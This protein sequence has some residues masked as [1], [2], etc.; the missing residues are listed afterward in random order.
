MKQAILFV[1]GAMLSACT[2]GGGQGSSE[3]DLQG[4]CEALVSAETGVQAADVNVVSTESVPT[5]TIT[6]IEVTG[7]QAP[8]LCL[9]DATG[10]IIGVEYS[11]EG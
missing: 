8:W 1:V 5:G 10:V 7:A 11:Q 9:A 3:T 2:Q 4:S 6:T